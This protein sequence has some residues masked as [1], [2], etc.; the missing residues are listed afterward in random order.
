M[1]DKKFDNPQTANLNKVLEDCEV[2]K[3]CLDQI[4]TAQTNKDGEVASDI[5]SR[6][7]SSTATTTSV[8]KTIY[9]SIWLCVITNGQSDPLGG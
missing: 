2:L 5:A 9:T 7:S 3:I 6:S 8:S 1:G 4:K